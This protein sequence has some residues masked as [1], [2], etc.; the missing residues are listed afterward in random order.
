MVL[1]LKN[2]IIINIDSTLNQQEHFFFRSIL[3]SFSFIFILLFCW[4]LN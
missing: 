4:D 3:A 2:D 1:D